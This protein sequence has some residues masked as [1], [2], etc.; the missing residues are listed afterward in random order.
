MRLNISINDAGVCSHSGS[1]S[2]RAYIL[3]EV[4][5]ISFALKRGEIKICC[6]FLVGLPYLVCSKLLNRACLPVSKHTL[7]LSTTASYFFSFLFVFLLF[8]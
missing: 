5:L 4:F 1:K 2:C 8:E 6:G 7:A 3:R